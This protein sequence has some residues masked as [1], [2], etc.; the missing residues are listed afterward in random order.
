MK[1]RTKF[2]YLITIISGNPPLISGS[3]H[4]TVETVFLTTFGYEIISD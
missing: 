4:S 1:K 3:F 2:S